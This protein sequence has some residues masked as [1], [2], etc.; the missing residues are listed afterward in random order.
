MISVGMSDS[1]Y[2][3][4]ALF[5]SFMNISLHCLLIEVLHIRRSAF[6]VWLRGMVLVG[7]HIIRQAAFNL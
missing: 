7:I 5:L 2:R 1:P 6:Y 3:F 4:R